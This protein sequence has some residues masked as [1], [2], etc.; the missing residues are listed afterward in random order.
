MSPSCASVA[1]AAGRIKNSIRS[2]GPWDRRT[3]GSRLPS[4]TP[5]PH[6]AFAPEILV[7][8]EGNVWVRESSLRGAEQTQWSVFAPGGELLGG[9]DMPPGLE[10]LEIGN[11]YVLGLAR[12]ELGVE[13]VL[14]Y[15]IRK[16]PKSSPQTPAKGFRCGRCHNEPG[17]VHVTVP[18]PLTSGGPGTR[19]TRPTTTGR[20]WRG[21]R[22]PKPIRRRDRCPAAPGVRSSVPTGL[23]QPAF[24]G[25][26]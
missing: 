2:R 17:I 26:R 21:T 6:P 3:I 12:D 14:K 5:T 7:D 15:R 13:Y 23:W 24:P 16:G 4:V 11:D 20:R 25:S 1:S 18:I 19:R 8:P 10:V 9:V 22:P